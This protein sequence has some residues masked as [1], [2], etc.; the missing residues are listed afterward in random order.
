LKL[1]H[2]MFILLAVPAFW[3]KGKGRLKQLLLLSCGQANLRCSWMY[4]VQFKGH[5]QIHTL[6]SHSLLDSNSRSSLAFCSLR[7]E[8]W[9][10]V[11]AWPLSQKFWVSF[12]VEI[13]T[14]AFK[15]A[16]TNLGLGVTTKK[17]WN[18]PEILKTGREVHKTSI[19]ETPSL[20]IIASGRSQIGA[21]FTQFSKV[22]LRINS[23]FATLLRVLIYPLG[24]FQSNKNFDI[25]P[26]WGFSLQGEFSK[27][28][29]FEIQRK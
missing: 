23:I 22:F 18:L 5:P 15:Q 10:A 12:R 19:W 29:G 8:G 9:Q 28:S 7:H 16:M 1:C 27:H 4:S 26:Y 21:H 17:K 3:I 24:K 14:E 13:H 20:R 2:D 6:S 25:D 11:M